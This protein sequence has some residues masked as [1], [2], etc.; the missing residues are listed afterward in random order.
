[1]SKFYLFYDT[2]RC[3]KGIIIE[4]PDAKTNLLFLSTTFSFHSFRY[5]KER[6]H[7]YYKGRVLENALQTRLAPLFLLCLRIL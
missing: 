3:F 6:K 7:A 2:G 1:M 5:I 4:R